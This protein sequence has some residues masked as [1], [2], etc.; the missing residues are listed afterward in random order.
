MKIFEVVITLVVMSVVIAS[1][2]LLFKVKPNWTLAIKGFL[3]SGDIA[4]GTGLY[5]AIG[6]IGQLYNHFISDELPITAGIDTDTSPV[7]YHRCDCGPSFNHPREQYGHNGTRNRGR[8]RTPRGSTWWEDGRY[9]RPRKIGTRIE[10]IARSICLFAEPSRRS[11]SH[12]RQ[13]SASGTWNQKKKLRKLSQLFVSC[14][15]WYRRLI[16]HVTI[17]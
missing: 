6:I 8:R 10:W 16:I 17:E 4:K 15:L 5:T 2:I 1:L 9:I 13:W 11:Y 7:F 12:G 14:H 3:P